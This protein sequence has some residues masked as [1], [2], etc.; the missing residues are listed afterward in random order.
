[1]PTKQKTK[2]DEAIRPKDIARFRD[3]E[4]RSFSLELPYS[5]FVALREELGVDFSEKTIVDELTRVLNDVELLYNVVSF[6]VADQLELHADDLTR[7]NW[8]DSM[9]GTSSSDDDA[10][11]PLEAAGHALAQVVVG[12]IQNPRLR[13]SARKRLV[14][15]KASVDALFDE[16]DSQLDSADPTA[17]GKMIAEKI[18][19][20]NTLMERLEKAADTV[21]STSS[22][23]SAPDDSASPPGTTHSDN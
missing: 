23:G 5:K 3:L 1:M 15:Q 8:V 9:F 7:E 16:E 12:F 20:G 10:E 2:P 14:L 4:G 21:L 11:G 22:S 19:S 18:T 6:L 13:K 17:I